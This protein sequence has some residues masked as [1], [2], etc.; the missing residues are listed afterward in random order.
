MVSVAQGAVPLAEVVRGGLVESV[1]LGH[2]VVLDPDGTVVLAA[3]D[4]DVEIW[5]RSSLKPVQAVAMLR[6]GLELPADQLAL[7]AASHD[8]TPR[9]V[10]VARQILAGAGLAEE[11]LANTPD[12]PYD[13]QAAAAWQGAGHGPDRLTQN[14]SGKHAA[15]LATCRV[16]GWPLEGYLAVDHP[17]QQAVRAAVVE[18]AGPDAARRVTVDGCG[19]PLFSTTLAGLARSFSRLVQAPA[20]SPA[21][22]VVAAMTAFPELV[23]GD[24]RDATRA[25][26]AV[27]GLLAKDGA[28]GVYAAAL[29][30][31]AALAFKVLDGASRPRPAV[32]AAALRVA[33]A[34]DVPGADEAALDALG[35]TSVLGGGAPV[36]EVRSTVAVRA[37]VA[38]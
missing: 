19:A 8:G 31:G 34:L 23:G 37:E 5:P 28:D 14:C 1:H 4:P 16:A 15:M 12:L 9:H 36:G 10:G 22:R 30:G 20:G 11:S 35:A 6:A 18:L 7:A 29:P 38:S 25:M 2:L 32:L 21:Q 33:G 26:R 17:L 3:G 27:P 13:P 24:G